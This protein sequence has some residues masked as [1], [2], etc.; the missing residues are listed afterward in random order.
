MRRDFYKHLQEEIDD[1]KEKGTYKNFK[2]NT[3]ALD[4]KI[5]VDGFG[6]VIVLCS[7]NYL[8]LANNPVINAESGSDSIIIR[9]FTT[10][11]A[12]LF[13]IGNIFGMLA[14][15]RVMRVFFGKRRTRFPVAAF[16]YFLSWAAFGVQAWYG[17]IFWVLALF[18]SSLFF[19][20]F[21]Y[22]SV[23]SKRLI[24]VTGCFLLFQSC[25]IIYQF[26]RVIFI[27][28]G[29]PVYFAAFAY[30][31]ASL[32][33]YGVM[34]LISRLCKNISKITDSLHKLWLPFLFFPIAYFLTFIFVHINYTATVMIQQFTVFFGT[35]LI[36]FFFYDT[37]SKTIESNIQSAL[38]SQEKEY[39]YSQCQLMQ[40][41]AE[42]VKSLRHDMKAHLAA[43]RDFS[44]GNKEA[45]EY[46]NRLLSGINNSEIYSDTGNIGFDSVINYKLKNVLEDGI[47]LDIKI[48]IPPALNVEVADIVTILGNLLDNALNAVVKTEDKMIRLNVSFDK[49]AL[50]INIENTFDGAVKYAEDK[51]T[52]ITLRDGG[53]HGHGLKNIRKS[54]EKYNGHMEINHDKNIFSVGIML[55]VNEAQ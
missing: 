53:A 4:G 2:Y 41:S 3:N 18:Y 12:F 24:A 10:N 48:F 23:I 8:G 6:E 37:V 33:M 32:L 25:T 27:P 36:F 47:K 51:K 40:E 52:I 17:Q 43:L 30:I 14:V 39:Y 50:F 16:I 31:A 15:E 45:V 28:G 11:Y 29:L 26:I 20:S 49:G 38:L 46:I 22:K 1:L 5:N 44:A 7:N 21:N 9:I 13:Y 34:F 54:V 42:Q 19:L 35:T 55:Y